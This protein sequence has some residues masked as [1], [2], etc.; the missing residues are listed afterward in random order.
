MSNYS[1]NGVELPGVSSEI[2]AK[3]PKLTLVSDVYN[4]TD[5]VIFASTG[6]AQIWYDI[7][8]VEYGSYVVL[9]FPDKG[10]MLVLRTDNTWDVTEYDSANNIIDNGFW[11]S[12]ML[13]TDDNGTLATIEWSNHS[14][15]DVSGE[16]YYSADGDPVPVEPEEPEEPVEPDEP[17]EPAEPEEKKNFCLRSWLTGYALGLAGK[18]L[19][20]DAK[21]LVAYLYNGV[22]LPPLPDWDKEKYPYAYIGR[23]RISDTISGSYYLY[24]TDIPFTFSDPKVI[25]TGIT[26]TSFILPPS[27]EGTWSPSSTDKYSEEMSAHRSPSV[28][29][30]YDIISDDGSVYLAASEPVPVY[31]TEVTTDG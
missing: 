29:S 15:Y 2:S 1:Y 23:T 26:I 18:P 25:A 19:S 4:A 14:I 10:A 20:F 12:V 3:Y 21:V 8:P 16:L 28:W 6:P 30:N 5:H 31:A 24:F 7:E 13:A 9:R 11:R 17:E 22:E 27:R